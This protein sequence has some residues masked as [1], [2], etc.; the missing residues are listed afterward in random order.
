MID[1]KFSDEKLLEIKKQY[2]IDKQKNID[3]LNLQI[4][5]INEKLKNKNI[6]NEKKL[7]KELKDKQD[8]LLDVENDDFKGIHG[9][10]SL[11]GI[12]IKKIE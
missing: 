6:F 12:K 5:N 11:R 8:E 4:E 10:P 1:N 7:E 3:K 9:Y 2:F